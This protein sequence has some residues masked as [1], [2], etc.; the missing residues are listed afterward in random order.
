VGCFAVCG[1]AL[2]GRVGCGGL[3]SVCGGVGLRARAGP[4]RDSSFAA[5]SHGEHCTQPNPPSIAPRLNSNRRSRA[6]AATRTCCGDGEPPWPEPFVSRVPH[7]A[8][9]LRCSAEAAYGGRAA[10][11]KWRMMQNRD[12]C[13]ESSGPLPC[14]PVDEES[15]YGPRKH[16]I[17]RLC[18][19]STFR[20]SDPV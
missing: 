6:A 17:P 1:W 13:S 7:A 18:S 9:S 2:L 12:G 14:R 20:K 11:V 3:G 16:D 8:P 5:N 4:P 19:P 15:T 10:A